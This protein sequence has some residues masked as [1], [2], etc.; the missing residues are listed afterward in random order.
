MISRMPRPAKVSPDFRVGIIEAFREPPTHHILGYNMFAQRL[1]HRHLCASCRLR[2]CILSKQVARTR[3]PLPILTPQV[4]RPLITGRRFL[5]GSNV[6]VAQDQEQDQESE[7]QQYSPEAAATLARK[8]FGN[9]LPPDELNEEELR[10]YERLYCTPLELSEQEEVLVEGEGASDEIAGTGVLRENSRG[11][12]VEVGFDEFEIEGDQGEVLEDGE[13]VVVQ[14]RADEELLSDMT[15]AMSSGEVGVEDGMVEEE[16]GSYAR[17]HPLTPPNRFKTSPSTLPLPMQGLV[18]PIAAQLSHVSNTHLKQTAHR[19]FGGLGLPWSTSTPAIGKTLQ[20]RP[21]PL[22][23]GRSNMSEMEADVFMAS[24]LPGMYASIM[25]VLVETRKRLG[26]EW[27]E[28]MVRKAASGELRVLDAGGAGAGV[29]AVREVLKAEWERMHQEQ[30]TG[31][32]MAEADGKVG[33]ASASPPVGSA[34]VLVGSDELRRRASLLLENT[35]FIPRLPNYLNTENARKKGKFD[36]VIAPHN[37]WGLK[38]DYI[39]KA[40]LEN[41]WSMLRHDGGVLVLLEKGVAR[42]F[43]IVAGAREMLLDHHILLPSVS[44]DNMAEDGNERSSSPQQ[45]GEGEGGTIIA[46][47]TTHALCP[48]YSP[49]GMVKGRRD[50]CHFSQRYVRPSFLQTILGAKDKNFE[51]V[52]FSYLSVMRGR[53]LLEGQEQKVVQD[54]EA[55]DAAFAGYEHISDPEAVQSLALPRAVLPPLKRRGHV[56]LD[57]CT[58][59]G[60]LERWTV[61]RSFSRQAFRDARKSSWGD[62]WALGAKTRVPRVPKVKKRKPKDTEDVLVEGE[63][64]MEWEG[65]TYGEITGSGGSGTGE[66]GRRRSGRKVKG[67]R[68]KRDKRGDGNGRRKRGGVVD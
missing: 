59:A 33:G 10:V 4:A 47:C 25:S 55:T 57:L 26:T 50:I 31:T 42:G 7:Q 12:L 36:I 15:A 1:A 19:V 41:L 40:H 52:K 18:G 35:T 11:E 34:T 39:R 65:D 5:Q 61:P 67:V 56:I 38:E 63:A 20:Q 53:N 9:Y 60:T 49:P 17:A 62:L 16:E 3:K 66:G 51:D 43:E 54:E 45:E 27:A 8:R 13:G 58:P 24:L 22:D 6:A 21:I 64:G 14:T 2:A 29:L 44:P 30:S 32:A 46:P 68:D 23:A 48:M 37:L 28:E